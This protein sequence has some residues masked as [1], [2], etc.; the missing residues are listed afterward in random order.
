MVL[1]SGGMKV[2]GSNQPGAGSTNWA[3]QAQTTT[4]ECSTITDQAARRK[5]RQEKRQRG[6]GTPTAKYTAGSGALGT[7]PVQ[8][9]GTAATVRPTGGFD[10]QIQQAQLHA[11]AGSYAAGLGSPYGLATAAKNPGA[12]VQNYM[13]GQF[14]VAPNSM[15]VNLAN[16]Y[17]APTQERMQA[18]LGE[19]PGTN[20]DAAN[21]GA[22]L[23]KQLGGGIGVQLDPIRMIATIVDGIQR[24][25]GEDLPPESVGPGT[26]ASVLSNPDPLAGINALT[27]ML[28]GALAGTMPD[29]SL[30]SWLESLTA[31]ATQYITSKGGMMGQSLD[32]IAADEGGGRGWFDKLLGTLGPSLGLQ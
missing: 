14:G 3:Q 21:F 26:F 22:A 9:A 23:L 20:I 31:Y 6:G 1:P 27:S 13:S 12:L 15:S 25:G 4:D 19:L 28:G 30:R 8:P 32:E 10:Q 16:Q 18:I 7:T 2:P 17:L 5:C 24:S 29:E 11:P